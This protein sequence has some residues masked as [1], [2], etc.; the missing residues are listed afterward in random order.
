LART[1]CFT[2]AAHPA[3]GLYIIASGLGIVSLLL[4]S[5]E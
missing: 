5:I 2:V 1:L 4:G 3:D